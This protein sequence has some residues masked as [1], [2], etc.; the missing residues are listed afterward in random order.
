MTFSYGVITHID[1]KGNYAAA[2][3]LRIREG[4]GPYEV[5]DPD[6]DVA[7]FLK[8]GQ[9]VFSLGEILVLDDSGREVAGL[10]RK[11]SKWRVT[12]E[13]FYD[14]ALAVERAREVSGVEV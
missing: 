4:N 5:P 1:P 9:P 12:Y 13:L 7:L 6:L 8:F 14:I 11:P 2:T 3:N 10:G